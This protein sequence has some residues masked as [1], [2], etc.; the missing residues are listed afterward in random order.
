[1]NADGKGTSNGFSF[2]E[3]SSKSFD[4]IVADDLK[5]DADED[6]IINASN[7]KEL[8][9]K[10][11]LIAVGVIAVLAIAFSLLVLKPFGGE[12]NVG[13]NGTDTETIEPTE[14]PEPEPTPEVTHTFEPNEDI[15]DDFYL[16]ERNRFPVD[17]EEWQEEPFV[18]ENEAKP[19]ENEDGEEVMRV[20]YSNIDQPSVLQT[21]E[22]TSLMNSAGTLPSEAAGFTSDVTKV[23]L[24]DGSLNPDFS[25]WT[26]EVFTL[27]TGMHIERLI[28]PTV[29]NWSYYQYSQAGGTFQINAI[30]DM[31]SDDWFER[32][33][34]KKLSE[35][36]PVY[37][38]WNAND[39]GMADK[40]LA[41]G[42]RWYGKVTDSTS[43]FVY[44][45]ETLQ[46]TVNFTADVSF[47]SW[48]K[49]Q[50]KLEK[51]GTLTLKLISNANGANS[52]GYRVVIDDASLKVD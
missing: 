26:T 3:D 22:G 14:A 30:A 47:T 38:D 19:V 41:S 5:S 31:F 2:D 44:D 39:Y 51:T 33:A 49:D 7:R 43:E 11:G 52:S 36:V 23:E 34:G 20:D 37:A 40:L 32:N 4:E 35:Y 18:V 17:T 12:Q 8:F 15:D 10:V 16:E 24:E 9:K 25:Y 29:G 6:K 21:W 13:N 48:A 45:M 46:Y 42:P 1:M 28:N 27:Q 50:T